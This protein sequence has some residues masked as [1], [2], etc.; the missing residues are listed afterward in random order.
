MLHKIRRDS[1]YPALRERAVR[2]KDK[3]GNL[4]T[5]NPDTFVDDWIEAVGDWALQE[6]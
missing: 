2:L 4:S 3:K 1:L 5:P 6:L